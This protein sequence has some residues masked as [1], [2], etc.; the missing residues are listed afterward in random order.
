MIGRNVPDKYE[1]LV[2][3][4]MQAQSASKTGPVVKASQDPSADLRKWRQKAISAVRRGGSA[5][6]PF[7]SDAIPATHRDLISKGLETAG[8]VEDVWALFGEPRQEAQRPDLGSRALSVA[9]AAQAEDEQVQAD[10]IAKMAAEQ[11]EQH[12]RDMA[13]VVALVK[14]TVERPIVVNVAPPP[15]A[16]VHV[17]APVV[18]IPR[19]PV[20]VVNVP[21]PIVKVEAS[22]PT[23]KNVE[24]DAEGRIVRVVES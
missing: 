17:A 24:R 9:Y 4:R 14:A 12:G 3:G 20:P 22:R 15:P 18:N 10:R 6:V 7:E 13:S 5:V 16:E 23:T 19:Q 21:A 1:P 8:T 2:T 11:A